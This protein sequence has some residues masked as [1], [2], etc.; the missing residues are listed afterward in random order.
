[1][2]RQTRQRAAVRD[3]LESGDRPMSPENVLASAQRRVPS[4]GI[5]TVYRAIRGLV[6]AGWLVPVDLPG[7]PRRYEV[8]GKDHHHHFHCR[9]CGQVFE[10]FGCVAGF[11]ALAPRGF[12]VTGHEVVLYGYCQPCRHETRTS[13]AARTGRP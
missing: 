12:R 5:A 2:I 6:E 8:A 4:L 3:A 1:M 11:P 7:Q 13:I 10:V 9:R